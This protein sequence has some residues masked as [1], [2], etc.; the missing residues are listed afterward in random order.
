MARVLVLSRG[1]EEA[2]LTLPEVIAVVKEGFISFRSGESVSYPVVRE[3]IQKYEGIFGIKS[4]YVKSGDYL[5]FK[6][7]G[8]W[9]ENPRKGILAHQSLVALFNPETGMPEAILDGNF[10]TI[11][12][13]GAAGAIASECLARKDSKVAAI[14]GCGTQGRIQ[15]RAL[16]ESF[17]LIS[18]RCYDAIRNSAKAFATEMSIPG[19]PVKICTLPE[20]AVNGA[21]IIVTTTPSTSPIIRAE[22]ISEGTHISAMGAD[23]KGKQ[24]IHQEL[25]QKSKVVVDDLGQCS[26]L[27]ETQHNLGF[28]AKH[29]IHAQLGDILSGEKL[30]RQTDNEITLFDATGI[31]FQDLV[32]AGLAMR[33]AKEKGMGIWVD[34]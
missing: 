23:T 2:V 20:E 3:F 25:Y 14:I 8:Y 26:E 21:D 5:G 10:I 17:H 4:G 16:R 30:G 1:D 34:L 15:L 19:S 22:W 9:K 11:I 24:E 7:G 18:V 28:V 12:R 13:T 33:L 6:A 31:A 29:G 27:G 32:T